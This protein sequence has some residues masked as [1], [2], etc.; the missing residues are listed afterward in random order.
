M[1]YVKEVLRLVG[2]IILVPILAFGFVATVAWAATTPNSYIA[3][4]TPN[5]GIVQ[6]LQGTDNAGVYKTLYTSGS[7]GSRCYGM[8]MTSTDSTAH[9]VTVQINNASVKYG[10]TAV[11]TGTTTP[12]FAN[13]APAINLMSAGNWPGLPVDQYGNP[14]VQLV[15][16]DT[17]QATF[18]TNLTASN[19][20]NIV[21][22]CSDF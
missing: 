9:L 11:T 16:G 18:A 12:G 19:L 2:N 20:V 3:P 7:N 15:S 17:I 13:G 8:W 6:F 14:Y 1:Q 21:A 5:R 22:S 10:G 4:Q